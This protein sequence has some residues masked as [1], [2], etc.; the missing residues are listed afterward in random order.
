MNEVLEDKVLVCRECGQEFVFT[1]GEQEFYIE[2][3]F[4]NE[5]KKC[6]SCRDQA[7]NASRTEHEIF[8]TDCATEGCGNPARVKFRPSEGRAVYCSDCFAKMREGN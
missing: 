3:G 5:P 6:K 7:K 4:Q 1:A 8:V 2:K